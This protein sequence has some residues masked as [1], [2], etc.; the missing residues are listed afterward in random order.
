MD[1]WE[2]EEFS[3][4]DYEKTKRSN[5]DN[6]QEEIVKLFWILVFGRT[7]SVGRSERELFIEDC[8]MFVEG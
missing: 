5:E 2:P 7:M 4:S 6:G 3:E 1:D 8:E